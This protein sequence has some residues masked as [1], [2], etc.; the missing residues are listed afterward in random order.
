VSRL[1]HSEKSSA[2]TR[3]G[4]QKT[5]GRMIRAAIV[6]AFRQNRYFPGSGGGSKTK[7]GAVG[8]R[9]CWKGTRGGK[10]LPTKKSQDGAALE[11]GFRNGH[12]EDVFETER[13]IEKLWGR[14][15]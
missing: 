2:A 11:D 15:K 9:N 14:T 10:Y 3:M 4:D 13:Q 12:A 7:T 1:N 6:T 5:R 8:D